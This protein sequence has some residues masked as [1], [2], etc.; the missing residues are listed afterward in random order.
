MLCVIFQKRKDSAK[1]RTVLGVVRL[2]LVLMRVV[3][4]RKKV[5][6]VVY[7]AVT[8]ALKLCLVMICATC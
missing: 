8:R 2:C 3:W 1:G 6:G 4:Q 5:L 7:P